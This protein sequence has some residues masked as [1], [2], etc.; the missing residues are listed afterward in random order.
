MPIILSTTWRLDWPQQ[1]QGQRC[2]SW[3]HMISLDT[4]TKTRLARQHESMVGCWPEVGN[5]VRHVQLEEQNKRMC[6]KSQSTSWQGCKLN[7]LG[8]DCACK[9]TEE[10]TKCD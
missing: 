4:V 10:W 5:H 9:K 1:L 7:L 8:H 6:L 3:R 2:R